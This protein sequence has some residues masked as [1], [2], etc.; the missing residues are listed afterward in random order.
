MET[1]R[2][3]AKA[4]GGVGYD[5]LVLFFPQSDSNVHCLKNR[6]T[7]KWGCQTMNW[8][9]MAS[10]AAAP[11]FKNHNNHCLVITNVMSSLVH[12]IWAGLLTV[13]ATL[14]DYIRTCQIRYLYCAKCM[15]MWVM[16][17]LTGI[18][19]CTRS[20]AQKGSGIVP[21]RND[22]IRRTYKTMTTRFHMKIYSQ[23]KC[24]VIGRKRRNLDWVTQD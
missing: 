10:G 21:T 20:N 18:C 3:Y 1:D 2:P 6:A 5:I 12:I 23:P 24:I 16:D 14:V 15:L 19:L 8:M 13:I 4:T 17:S 11:I 22:S 7:I 9:G